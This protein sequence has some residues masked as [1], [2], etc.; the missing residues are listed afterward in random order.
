MAKKIGAVNTILNQD[1]L[2]TGYNSDAMGAVT[3]L[4]GRISLKNQRVAIVG[5]GG[6]ARAIGFGILE[7]QGKVI[8]VNRTK[9]TGERLAAD[10]GGDFYPLAEIERVDCDVLINTTPVGMFPNVD[11]TP[12]PGT[13]F[14]EHMTVMDIIYTPLRTRLL[15]EATAAGCVT[16]QGLPMF[17]YQGA[18]QF[19]LWT[20]MRAPV[21]A[22][23]GAVSEA[24]G[25]D[26]F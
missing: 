7:N 8:V 15:K 16:I 11:A 20:G 13:F 2:L 12:V 5:A 10:L 25:L 24:L 17:I 1:G 26:E 23:K 6:A 4:K 9:K 14:A 21:E 3:A 18:F 19:E 22:M